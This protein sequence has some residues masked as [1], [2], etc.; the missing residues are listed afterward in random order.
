MKT[1]KLFCIAV[2]MCYATSTS[3]AQTLQA[4]HEIVKNLQD[5]LN[6]NTE[7]AGFQTGKQEYFH[8][9]YKYISRTYP[10][11]TNSNYI[12]TAAYLTSISASFSSPNFIYD[13]SFYALLSL[14]RNNWQ[15]LSNKYP[16]TNNNKIIAAAY[17]VKDIG[18]EYFSNSLFSSSTAVLDSFIRINPDYINIDYTED[19]ILITDFGQNDVPINFLGEY[20]VEFD[21]VNGAEVII[22]ENDCNKHFYY[23]PDLDCIDDTIYYAYKICDSS[24]N[25]VNSYNDGENRIVIH[26]NYDLYQAA[27]TSIDTVLNYYD[28]LI[29]DS[30]NFVNSALPF[31]VSNDYSN[32]NIIIIDS[33][34]FKYIVPNSIDTVYSFIPIHYSC[35]DN[36]FDSLP[37]FITRPNFANKPFNDDPNLVFDYENAQGRIYWQFV[38]QTFIDSIQ[39][40]TITDAFLIVP[41]ASPEFLQ[42]AVITQ[43]PTDMFVPNA[44]MKNGLQNNPNNMNAILVNATWSRY[45]I[46]YSG[47]F[48]YKLPAFN[49]SNDFSTTIIS[50]FSE[51]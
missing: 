5:R 24:F 32:E 10:G 36:T 8:K 43:S 33:F 13:S 37:I 45:G 50:T 20:E 38:P 51:N 42:D 27:I 25:L 16:N 15:Y 46:N 21:W 4:Q 41:N 14:Y 44:S 22:N 17:M 2:L 34:S 11:E 35:N 7:Y 48:T 19:S 39:N 9:F 3:K 12:N 40:F 1:L 31:Y 26:T 6:Q 30:R 47:T 18:T 23:K 28:T 29:I 49:T